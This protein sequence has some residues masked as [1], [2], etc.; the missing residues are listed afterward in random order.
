M[1]Q[2]V[3][4]TDKIVKS[5]Y[6]N[7]VLHGVDFH[8]G[9]GEIHGLV[10]GNGAGKS[11]L[12]KIINGVYSK[13]EGVIQVDGKEANY[14]TVLDAQNIGI[15]MVYQEFSL[16]P[17]MSVADNLLLAREPIKSGLI[18]KKSINEKAGEVF[19]RLNVKIDPL[20]NIEDLS[21]GNMQI[22]EIAKAI[23]LNNTKV[24]ILDEPTASLSKVEIESLFNTMR[25]L[26]EKGISIIL[27][28]HHLSEIMEICD[29]VTVLRDGINVLS[30]SIADT[31]LEEIIS[32]MLGQSAS[33]HEYIPPSVK[34]SR[35]PI[36]EVKHLCWKD[37]VKDVSFSLYGGEV[38]GLVGAMGSGKTE[39][40]NMLFGLSRPD[41]GEILLRGKQLHLN[42]PK[43]AIQ[44]GISMVPEDRRT[45]GIIAEHSIRMNVLLPIWSKLLNLFFIKDKE[46]I[47]LTQKYIDKMDVKCQNIEE[48]IGTLS[49]GNQ[50]KV[51]FAKSLVS[52]PEVFLLDDPTVGV[53]IAAKSSI[54]KLIRSLADEGKAILLVSGEFD[55]IEKIAEKVLIFS[56]G[57]IT[58][59]IIRGQDEISETSLTAAV[60]KKSN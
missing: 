49:G 50:Q 44:Y 48:K 15:S 32:A 41:S 27:V 3:L 12:M 18:D 45:C 39:L 21:V 51:V 38:L 11:T 6:K 19:K 20:T 34:R 26:K 36:L 5:F 4:S 13:D 7:E 25:E 31:N 37:R 1:N 29:K 2:Y 22:V 35:A 60:Y 59:T 30:K 9:Y 57:R 58:E 54:S 46:G 14:N 52:A 47:K 8:V 56:D 53:D 55:E 10:G 40:L 42:H 33:A 24:L 23:V 28:S 16:I 43:A 17:T